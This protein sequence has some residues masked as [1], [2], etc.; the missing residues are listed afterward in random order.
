[1]TRSG[2]ASD[3]GNTADAEIAQP[4]AAPTVIL[5][6]DSLASESQNHFRAALVGAG[7]ADV[8]T[9]TFG[10]TAL[11]DWLA[12]MREDADAL[13]P[14]AVVIEF[15]GNALTPCMHDANSAPLTG[16]AY[17]AK[18]LEGATEALAIF[19]RSGTR[20]YFVGAPLTR[21]AAESGARAAGRLNALYAALGSARFV[22]YVDAGAAVLDHGAWTSVLPCLSDE[23]CTGGTDATGTRVN[24]V[25]AADGT[26]FCPAPPTPD[27]AATG[28]C[29]V[30]S[31]GAFRFGTAIAQPVIRDLRPRPSNT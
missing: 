18:Y 2:S 4:G 15:S 11:C 13:H 12:A 9:R 31:S 21:R 3:V 28:D 23:P 27:A 25:R 30:W 22:R 20:V 14:R 19:S 6:G 24:V 26:H 8:H 10:G 17:Y 5:Y 29:P 1:M 16:D 7:I